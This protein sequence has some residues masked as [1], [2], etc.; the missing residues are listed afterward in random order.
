HAV[1]NGKT[2]VTNAPIIGLQVANAKPGDSILLQSSP[3]ALSYKAFLRS[4]IAVDS[5]EIIYNGA[6]IAKHNLTGDKKNFD[7]SGFIN[8]SA[9][10]WLLLRAWGTTAGTNLFDIYPYAST[11]PIYLYDG[12]NKLHSKS[13]AEYFLQW[14]QRIENIAAN[15]PSYHNDEEKKS[16]MQ[17]IEKAKQFYMQCLQTANAP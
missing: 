1:K 14:V 17:D 9:P 4:N 11:N 8:V 7:A 2:F 3:Q 6:V 13:A 12:K 15:H 10:G 5:F 16:V